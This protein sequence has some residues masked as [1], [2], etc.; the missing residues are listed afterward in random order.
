MPRAFR[1]LQNLRRLCVGPHAQ[2]ALVTSSLPQEGKTTTSLCLAQSA[3]AEG[4]R[5]MLIDC[6][7]RRRSLSREIE[8]TSG[9]RASWKCWPATAGSRTR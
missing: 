3:A 4:L 8:R 2:V 9:P 1:N 6:D 7:L 5:V